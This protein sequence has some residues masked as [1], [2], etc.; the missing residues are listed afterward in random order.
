M[1]VDRT[2]KGNIGIARRRSS[3]FGNRRSREDTRPGIDVHR[4]A[5]ARQESVRDLEEH[6]YDRGKRRRVARNADSEVL[7]AGSG[8]ASRCP[9][10]EPIPACVH[11]DGIGV[12]RGCQQHSTNKYNDC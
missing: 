7:A 6:G 1:A 8:R 2:R 9:E 12:Q 4:E 5:V 3:A 10:T 11:D